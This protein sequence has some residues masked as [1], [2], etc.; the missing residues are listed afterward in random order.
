MDSIIKHKIEDLN[1]DSIG[2]GAEYETKFR[3]IHNLAC[4]QP[5]TEGRISDNWV[6]TFF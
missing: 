3:L 5:G 1:V 4:S 2:A 6:I